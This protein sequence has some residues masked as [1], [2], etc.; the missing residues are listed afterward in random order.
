MTDKEKL[1]TAIRAL[2]QCTNPSGAY[3]MD[4]LRHAENTIKNLSEQA[5]KALDEIGVDY[6]NVEIEQ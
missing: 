1:E 2:K 4:R 3:D 5:K 6:S